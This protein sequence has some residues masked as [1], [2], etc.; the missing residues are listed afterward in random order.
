MCMLGAAKPQALIPL[1]SSANPHAAFVHDPTQRTARSAAQR[2]AARPCRQTMQAQR[3]PSFAHSNAHTATRTQQRAH[4]PMQVG[5]GR[6]ASLGILIKGGDA[7][8]RASHVRTVVFDKTGTVTQGQPHA[9]D[10]EVF[11]GQVRAG[12]RARGG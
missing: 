12:V 10:M 7:L 5:T 4:A 11:E 9:V 6:A 3:H 8:E 1:Q 2:S